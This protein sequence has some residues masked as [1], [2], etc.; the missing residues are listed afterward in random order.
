MGVDR[1]EEMGRM[2]GGPLSACRPRALFVRAA[3]TPSER[4]CLG[5]ALGEEQ[6]GGG[7]A[8]CMGAKAM[9]RRNTEERR[10]ARAET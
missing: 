7:A 2:G 3:R 5:A 8:H 10:R 1:D 4:A 9:D 6:G